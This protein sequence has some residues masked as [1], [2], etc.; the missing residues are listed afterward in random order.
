M[1]N[2]F[3]KP[4]AEQPATAIAPEPQP[5]KS[6]GIAV[7]L[8]LGATLAAVLGGWWYQN[9]QVAAMRSELTATHQKIWCSIHT[10]AH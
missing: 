1:A 9:T 8:I 5:G 10:A 6:T 4:A 3:E 7:K 2:S